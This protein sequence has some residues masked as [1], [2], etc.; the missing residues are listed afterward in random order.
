MI[1]LEKM[2]VTMPEEKQNCLRQTVQRLIAR[3]GQKIKAKELA[4]D[5]AKMISCTPAL[6]RIPL[7]FARPAYRQV[8]SEV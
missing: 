4:Q 3:Q 7:I 2:Q 5:L 6:S 1:N 8:E